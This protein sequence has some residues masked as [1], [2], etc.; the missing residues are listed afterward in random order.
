MSTLFEHC[1]ALSQSFIGKL[2]GSA[3]RSRNRRSIGLSQYQSLEHRRLLAFAATPM[4]GDLGEFQ[5]ELVDTNANINGS[6]LYLASQGESNNFEVNLR[7]GYV[8]AFQEGTSIFDSLA[9]DLRSAEIDRVVVVGNQGQDRIQLRQFDFANLMPGKLWARSENF[10]FG[11]SESNSTGQ[12]QVFA[13]SVEQVK[14]TA[15]W[16]DY[17]S[18]P[19]SFEPKNLVRINGSN[20]ADEITMPNRSSSL[21]GRPSIEIQGQGFEIF[22][23]GFDDAVVRGNGGRDVAKVSGTAGADTYRSN[24]NYSTLQ[25]QTWRV[26]LA[27]VEWAKVDLGEGNDQATLVGGQQKLLL[28]QLGG[29]L[30]GGGHRLTGIEN[31]NVNLLE[32]NDDSLVADSSTTDYTL[33]RETSGDLDV[34]EFTASEQE[35]RWRFFGLE[36]YA[37]LG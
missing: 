17:F 10:L 28:R 23:D 27:D 18:I 7:L 29:E 20:G 12:I 19:D 8:R 36:K 30:I 25:T 9:F 24:N 26:A 6:T 1:K 13:T 3:R 5:T 16:N 15:Y 34:L 14:A 11:D 37:D 35:H 31:I 33:T 21:F 4:T 32:A 22:A 2:S